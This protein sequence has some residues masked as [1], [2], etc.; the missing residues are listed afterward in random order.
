MISVT[1]IL[2]KR[3]MA[4][5]GYPVKIRVYCSKVKVHR[6][7]RT[8]IYQKGK[9]LK[10]T[11]EVIRETSLAEER[12]DYCN[13]FALNLEDS[14]SIIQNGI[15]VEKDIQI[16]LL[17]KQLKELQK[18]SGAML[19]EFFDV[20]KNER[21]DSGRP[22]IDL[23]STKSQWVNFL[24]QGN[25]V[26]INNV[27]YE[28]LNSF[29][30][31]KKKYG[32]GKGG[33]KFYLATTRAVYKEAQR[34]KSMGI[35]S[36]NPF[37]GLIKSNKKKVMALHTS[38]QLKSLFEF[39]PRHGTTEKSKSIMQRN[40][41]L[42]FFQFSIGG[43]DYADIA[44]LKWENIKDDRVGF[45]R[46]KLRYKDDPGEYV[47]NF[48]SLYA[49]KVL[50]KYST[51]KNERVFAFIPTPGTTSYTNFN[52]LIGKSLGRIS[53]TLEIPKLKT[54]TP[55]YLFR[56]FAGELGI[57]TLRIDQIQG[58]RTDD[59]SSGYQRTFS[60]ELIDGEINRVLD[61]IF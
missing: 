32:K 46:F 28:F 9:L 23:E 3:R 36:D 47:D 44:N 26:R 31:Y 25:D 34:R 60:H 52:R 27:D 58:R 1:A 15:P 19:L 40:I 38:D 42:F 56:S 53:D 21:E 17:K 43:H 4:K 20:I 59:L 10:F 54:K 29:I 45:Y 22:F 8:T 50:K 55:R 37:L 33:I 35:K 41:A 11:S 7:I 16:L 49:K 6:A 24:G 30:L 5:S 39:E 51:P 57:D 48:L 13:K 18:D 14:L 2:D 12:A 61:V